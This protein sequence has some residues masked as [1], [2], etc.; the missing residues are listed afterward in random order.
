M[1]AMAKNPSLYNPKRYPERAKQ[2]GQVFFQMVK[3]GLLTVEE[4]DSLKMLPIELS[5][6]REHTR[7]SHRISV[8]TSVDT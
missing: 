8:S 2:P 7:G 6:T 4:K 5:R 3:N 1:V